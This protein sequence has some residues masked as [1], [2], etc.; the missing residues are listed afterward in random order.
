MKI[1]RWDL[2]GGIS[3]DIAL[4]A[5]LDLGAD[6]RRVEAAVRACGLEQVSLDVEAVAEAG[7]AGLRVAVRDR[8]PAGPH[9]HRAWREIRG[10][11][12]RA[13]LSARARELALRV[14]SRLAAAEGRVHRVTADEVEF[15]EI[16]AADSIADVVGA[17]V[18]LE[19]LG[20][21]AVETGPFPLGRGEVRCAHGVY[22]L[23]APAVIELLKGWPVRM[24]EEELETV[25]PTGAALLTEWAESLPARRGER[26]IR[27]AGLGWGWH[28]LRGRPNV[29]R[30][31]L[32][33]MVG[34]DAGS[35]DECLVL[36]TQM[37]DVTGEWI[38]VL[39]E[40]LLSAGALDVYTTAVQMK[41]QRPGTLLTVLCEPARRD[42][43]LEMIFRHS[44]TLGV[45]EYRA[46]RAVLERRHVTVNTRWGPVR[47]KLG[48][49]KGEVVTRAPEMEDCIARGDE[50]HVPPRCVYLEALRCTPIAAD[51][52]G[53]NEPVPLP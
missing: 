14:F 13:P 53:P 32:Y 52:G 48:V 15:H 36:E 49:W 18:A 25:T 41:K 2:V 17:C 39:V 38:G 19:L 30:A 10:L 21:E 3:G 5:L 35:P 28:R 31:V 45:R 46:D 16:G 24:V 43:M 7:L 42:A 40:R 47:V 23:P 20:V 8:T 37:D 22:P 51:S 50:H 26:V 9:A 34:D 27:A 33:E 6:R 4:A 11:L 12:D 44:P 1:L 29:A